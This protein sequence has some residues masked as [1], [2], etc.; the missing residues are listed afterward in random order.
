MPPL[1]TECDH[2]TVEQ[3]D[4]RGDGRLAI[5]AG[6]FQQAPPPSPPT[7]ISAPTRQQLT[8]DYRSI[9][10]LMTQLETEMKSYEKNYEGL[11]ATGADVTRLS[12][13]MDETRTDHLR[14]LHQR[15]ATANGI[16]EP[17]VTMRNNSND[18][19]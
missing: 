15:T 12:I 3:L 10:Q 16:T 2:T 13:L 7:E 9:T 18:L 1:P 4:V 14:D 11:L 5:D 6:H 17:E 19:I 8:N